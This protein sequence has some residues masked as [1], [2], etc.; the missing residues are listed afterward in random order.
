MDAGVSHMLCVC[1]QLETFSDVRQAAADYANVFASVGVHPNTDDAAREPSIDELLKLGRDPLIV[2]IGETGL[3]YFRSEGDLQWQ[4]DR[5]RC[6]IRAARELGKPLII[7]TRE[8]AADVIS[9]LREENAAGRRRGHALFRRRL[10]DCSSG[11]GPRLLY[12]VSGIVTFKSA[13]ALREVA[14]RVPLERLLIET[15]SPWLAPVPKRGKQN[16]PAFVRHT[17]EFLAK[18]RGMSLDELAEATLNNF[19]TLFNINTINK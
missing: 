5:F 18:L 16:E 11:N 13:S 6:H 10:G 4:R 19:F 17:A 15:D 8:A 3:D 1:V 9:I 2:A 7:H 14:G 12:I